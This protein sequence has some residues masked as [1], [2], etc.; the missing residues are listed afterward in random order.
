MAG[1]QGLLASGWSRVAHNKRY[2][3]WF[4]LLNVLLAWLG[5]AAFNSQVHGILD[6]S[7][8]AQRL[9]RG[10]DIGVFIEM[11][12]R[13]EFGPTTASMMPAAHFAFFFFLLTALFLPGVLQ[14]YA[15]TYRLPRQDFF[16]ACGRNLWRFV[17]LLLVAGIVMTALAAALFGLREALI[18]KAGESTN[19]L[20]SPEVSLVSLLIIFLVMAAMRI[21]FDLAQADIVLK[22]Q[23][24]VRKSIAAGFRPP[25][26]NLGLLIST[27]LLPSIF[28]A[29]AL[30]SR[31]LSP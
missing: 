7:L 5:A 28:P 12:A 9:V 31:P 2:I 25:W 23:H 30:L 16:R 13:P 29:P 1:N 8:Q 17:R 21:W 20:L 3:F 18:K 11:L 4:Y 27:C 22:D 26:R 15:S 24:A 6:H 10:F 14:G 19:E